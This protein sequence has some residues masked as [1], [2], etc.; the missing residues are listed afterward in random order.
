MP[1]HRKHSKERDTGRPY[2]DA[3]DDFQE[4]TENDTWPGMYGEGR[5]RRRSH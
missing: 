2:T 3:V 1:G 4:R 5:A